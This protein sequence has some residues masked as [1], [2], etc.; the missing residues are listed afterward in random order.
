MIPDETMTDSDIERPLIFANTCGDHDGV[1]VAGRMMHKLADAIDQLR[2][3]RDA[4]R[5]EGFR[6]ALEMAA[7]VL[8]DYDHI[9]EQ[10]AMKRISTMQPPAEWNVTAVGQADA[11][12]PHPDGFADGLTEKDNQE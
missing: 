7:S 4:A 6:L 5:I 3:Q 1:P 12:W 9:I 8:N 10:E 2:T 11:E